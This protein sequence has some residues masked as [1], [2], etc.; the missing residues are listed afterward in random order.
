MCI[1][2]FKAYWLRNAATGLTLKKYAFCT[3]TVCVLR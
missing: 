1:K 3:H 2:P